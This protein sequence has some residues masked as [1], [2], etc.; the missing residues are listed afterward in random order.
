MIPFND[1]ITYTCKSGFFFEEDIDMTN[2]TV[3]CHEDGSLSQ[4]RQMICVDPKGE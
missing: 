2:Y 1:S 4:T 3:M